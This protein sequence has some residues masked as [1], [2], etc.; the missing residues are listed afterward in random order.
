MEKMVELIKIAC[1]LFEDEK[2]MIISDMPEGYG[3]I[4]VWFKLLCLAGKRKKH[5][6][7]MLNDKVA[8]TDQMLASLFKMPFELVKKALDVF[9]QFGMTEIK[10]GVIWISNWDKYQNGKR[11]EVKEEVK[12]ES[13][14]RYSRAEYSDDFV[15]FWEKYPRKD[16][17]GAAYKEYMARLRSGFTVEELAEAEQNYINRLKRDRTELKYTKMAKTF[18]GSTLYFEQYINKDKEKKEVKENPFEDYVL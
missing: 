15:K 7:L 12:E 13:K 9:E 14:K 3:I 6:A 2:M 11:A 8:Y 18:L 1:D 10:D 16:D 4:V 5:G 17:K